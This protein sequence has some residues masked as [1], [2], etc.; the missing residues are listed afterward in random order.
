MA[1]EYFQTQDVTAASPTNTFADDGDGTGRHPY[2]KLEWGAHG[3]QKQVD[4]TAGNRLPV[5]VG[6]GLGAGSVVSGQGSLSGV[7][8]ALPTATA[9]RFRLKAHTDNT[10]VIYLGP[11]GVTTANG[12]PLWPGDLIDV[13]IS[14][15]NVIHAIVGSGTQKLAY[16]GLV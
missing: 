3:T 12:Y 16:L 10:D 13:E 7:E 14:N 11:T 5:K 2:S 1:L 8:A 4:D 9:R 15:L 6:D